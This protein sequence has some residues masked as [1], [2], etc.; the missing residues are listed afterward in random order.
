MN[1]TDISLGIQATPIYPL[2]Y[3]VPFLWLQLLISVEGSPLNHIPQPHLTDATASNIIIRTYF[4]V[5]Y[6][7]N[8][9]FVGR[10][11]LLD[12]IFKTLSD[13]RSHEYN[14]R[15]ACIEQSTPQFLE[16]K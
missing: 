3:L 10:T 8:Q 14:H 4:I 16:A 5:P 13:T 12:R 2:Q 15:V 11:N 9:F 1:K 7:R 6:A